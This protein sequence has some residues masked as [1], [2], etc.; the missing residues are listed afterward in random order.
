MEAEL[1]DSLTEAAAE[2]EVEDSAD[3]E[4]LL[5]ESGMGAAPMGTG[6]PSGPVSWGARFLTMRLRLM[7][8]RCWSGASW[9]ASATV[10]T[11]IRMAKPKRS[12]V[13]SFR[14][15]RASMLLVNIRFGWKSIKLEKWSEVV[16]SWLLAGSLL[17]VD[18]VA[19]YQ[20]ESERGQRQRRGRQ[21]RATESSDWE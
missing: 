17:G 4:A 12:V 2:T 19:K 11:A 16:D 1:A 7:W 21:Q 8:S 14:V 10:E 5:D 13:E 15:L 20:G 9:A 3:T 18:K 6:R